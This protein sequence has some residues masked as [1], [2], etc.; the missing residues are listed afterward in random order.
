[1]KR[2]LN[3]HSVLLPYILILAVVAVRLVV[4]HP[5]NFVPVF[6]VLVF[7]GASRPAREFALP[8]LGLMGVDLF[9]T[10]HQYGFTLTG[11]HAVT[12]LFYLAALRM[13]AAMAGKSTAAMRLA[14]TS[15]IIAATFFVASNFA[16]WAAWGMYPMTWSGLGAC[17]V[18]ALPFFRNS[19]MSETIGSLTIFAIARCYASVARTEWTE[20]ACR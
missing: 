6:S 20:A 4:A 11:D 5:Y 9:L 16:V 18:A 15:L 14:G 1:M 17:Y 13:G 3:E 8:L 19:V 12:W 2:F 10:T 7:F